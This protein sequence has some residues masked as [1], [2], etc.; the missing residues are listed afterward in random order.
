MTNS[1]SVTWMQHIQ[2]NAHIN[3]FTLLLSCLF[4]RKMS[5]ELYFAS[6]PDGNNARLQG[7][8]V[9]GSKPLHRFIRGQPKTIGVRHTQA[10]SNY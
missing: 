1:F 4:V 5:A 10:R 6:G 8:T 7:T 3:V 2:G 9:G